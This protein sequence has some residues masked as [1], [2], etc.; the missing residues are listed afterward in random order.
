MADATTK[1][2]PYIRVQGPEG[3]SQVLDQFLEENKQGKDLMIPRYVLYQLNQQQSLIRID[4]NQIPFKFWYCDLN[5]RPAT[6]AVKETIG[7]FLWEKCGKKVEDKE[8]I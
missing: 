7:R 3:L 6:K 2:P 4:I 8:I 5:G 1:L